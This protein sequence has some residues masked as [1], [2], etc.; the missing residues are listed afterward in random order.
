MCGHLAIILTVAYGVLASQSR[1]LGKVFGLVSTHLDSRGSQMVALVRHR[2]LV[3][4]R[5][6]AQDEGSET[7]LTE[8]E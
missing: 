6:F 5:S 4:R 1:Q 7:T 3:K 2:K 8:R